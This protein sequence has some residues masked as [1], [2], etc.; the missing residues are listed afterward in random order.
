MI[1]TPADRWRSAGKG[2]VSRGAM[3]SRTP[4]GGL[5]D[6]G[7]GTWVEAVGEVV[8]DRTG[9]PQEAGSAIAA[10]PLPKGRGTARR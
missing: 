10:A 7:F 3:R 6:D 4:I 9:Q 2:W 5:T 8:I 1:P